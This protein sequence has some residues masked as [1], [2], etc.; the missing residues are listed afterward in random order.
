MGRRSARLAITWVAACALAGCGGSDGGSDGADTQEISLP[1]ELPGYKDIVDAVKA[2][3][4]GFESTLEPSQKTAELT[5]SRYSE[6]F[7]GAASAYRGYAD[8]GLEQLVSVVAVRA[9]APGITYGRVSDAES[10]GLAKPPQEV[11]EAG[12]AECLVRWEPVPAHQ[13]VDPSAQRVEYCQRSGGGVTV[14]VYG[15]PFEGPEGLA[16][17]G[18]LATAAWEAVS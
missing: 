14:F 3:D 11:V 18:E 10:L 15:G 6:A 1:A 7:D 9:D 2:A 12:G 13:D 4:S 8:E 17:A 5:E 16:Q